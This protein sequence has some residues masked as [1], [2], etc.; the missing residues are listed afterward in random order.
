[1]AGRPGEARG[2]TDAS[3]AEDASTAWP[4]QSGRDGRQ[5]L[6]LPRGGCTR[7]H[8]LRAAFLPTVRT[9]HRRAF[10]RAASG[11]VL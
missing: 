9:V 1:M 5:R 7:G 10:S 11:W 4:G 8:P 3:W 6:I 2:R